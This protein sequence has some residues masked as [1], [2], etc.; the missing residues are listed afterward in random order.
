MP[1]PLSG[2]ARSDD[3]RSFK[4]V[5]E[6]TV[7]VVTAPGDG[8]SALWPSDEIDIPGDIGAEE[9]RFVNLHLEE[10]ADV[11]VR[12]EDLVSDVDI[13]LVGLDNEAFSFTS[14]N[15]LANSERIETRL[16]PGRYQITLSSFGGASSYLLILSSAA[17]E[18]SPLADSGNGYLQSEFDGRLQENWLS[19]SADGPGTVRVCLQPQV[20]DLDLEVFDLAGSRLGQSA[21]GGTL[22]DVVDIQVEG[23]TYYARV[24]RFGVDQGSVGR[25]TVTV[26][27]DSIG[28]VDLSGMTVRRRGTWIVGG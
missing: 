18:V 3:E 25:H 19:F 22:P 13:E 10:W 9:E 15:A 6:R 5:Y 7:P 4:F 11:V 27:R 26:S 14:L 28:L 16:A 2:T 8:A 20:N 21:E 24:Y 12:L 23:G 1:I 17:I